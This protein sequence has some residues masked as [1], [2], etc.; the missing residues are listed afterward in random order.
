MCIYVCIGACATHTVRMCVCDY[1]AQH[2]CCCVS[3][4]VC[5]VDF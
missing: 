1:I 3:I 2:M 4:Y 5:E